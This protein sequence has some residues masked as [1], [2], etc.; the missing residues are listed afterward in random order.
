MLL[1]LG[2]TLVASVALCALA[3]RLTILDRALQEQLLSERLEQAADLGRSAL[4]QQIAR[5]G[6][7]LRLALEAR[8][9]T[10]PSILAELGGQG[11]ERTAVLLEGRELRLFPERG[12]RY[13]PEATSPE[14]LAD[15]E[16]AHGE[17]LEHR[18][19]DYAA[20][21][22]WFGELAARSDGTLRAGALLRTARN[23]V[24]RKQPA[25]ALRAYD[26]LARMDAVMLDGEPA[27]LVARHARLQLLAAQSR[28]V[29]AAVLFGDLESGKWPLS[30]TSYQYYRNELVS[31]ASLSAGV[32]LWEEAVH[33]LASLSRA[34]GH[35]SGEQVVW[36]DGSHPLLLIWRSRSGSVAA[37]ALTGKHLADEWLGMGRGFSY[38]IETA[39]RR[40][41]VPPHPADR[42][43]ERV[44]SFAGQDWRLLATPT[45]PV[46]PR[47]TQSLLVAGLSLVIILVLTGSY[48]VMRAVS[49]ELAV[50]RLQADFVSA[51]SHEFRSPLT[52]LRSMSE[53]LERGRVP[54][55]ERKQR[56]YELMARETGRL[57]RLV[58]DLLDFGRMEAGA[59][60]YDL[61]PTDVAVLTSQAI[62]EF[63]EEVAASGFRIELVEVHA[64]PVVA[65]MEA[66]R[67]AVRNLL[68]NAVKYSGDSREIRVAVRTDGR[69]VFISVQD[70]GMGISSQDARRIFRKFERGAEAK[71]S[72]IAGTGLGLALVSSIMRAHGGAVRVES[73]LGE[74]SIFTLSLP[75]ATA[76]DE[77]VAWH[78]SS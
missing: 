63:Q 73:T 25:R 19:R 54:T 41:L 26:E 75:S 12:L 78:A 32:P 36:V 35:E 24:K 16:F 4:L 3:W 44:L 27:P 51:V 60:Q 33:A 50:A 28:P 5:A 9:E 64:A 46:A 65:D 18:N 10:R 21:A 1:L 58:E 40:I 56:Y 62:S 22:R 39:D 31:V 17:A 8:S 6:D 49:R 42:H 53:M 71:A 43:T 48:A 30:R 7:Q 23:E 76:A 55:E 61:R 20:A 38:G 45:A 2:V 74:G 67:G 37:L 13:I 66:L 77:K 72:S 57:H 14:V 59:R 15:A 34:A 52:T 47:G 69:H 68:D 70:R 11:L 29:E